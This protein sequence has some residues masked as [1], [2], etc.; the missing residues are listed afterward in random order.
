ME[1]LEIQIENVAPEKSERLTAALMDT[2]CESFAEEEGRFC[3]YIPVHV[4]D[5][6]KLKQVLGSVLGFDHARFS[7][8][9]LEDKNWNEEWEKSYEPVLI[10]G[11]CLIRAP[12]HLP[13]SG[14]KYDIVIEPKMS[15][16]TAHHE[17]TALLI[18]WLLEEPVAGKHVLD[19]GCGTGVLAILAAKQGA[20]EVRAIDNDEW[21]YRNASENCLR[22]NVPHVHV[23][24]GDDGAIP[25][26]PFDVILANINRNVLLEQIP[27]YDRVLGAGGLLYL[28]GFYQAD[29]EVIREQAGACGFDYV[30]SREKNGWLAVKFLK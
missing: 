20:K 13:V 14:V 28:S 21:A 25:W 2:G 8:N 22:N 5:E 17:T 23:I 6:N 19:M 10:G 26:G 16:G 9:R 15:F 12:F 4:Y 24:H 30:D 7:V 3:A 11:K 1:Y 29:L 18:E 27:V